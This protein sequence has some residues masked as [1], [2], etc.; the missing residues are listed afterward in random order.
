MSEGNGI[1]REQRVVKNEVEFRAYN[2]RREQMERGT[3][4]GP[5]PFV[6]ECGDGQCIRALSATAEE[7]ERAHAREDQFLVLPGH[8][9]PEYERV[10]ERGDRHWVVQK[11]VRPSDALDG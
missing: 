9:Y 4:E 7:W 6:C 5:L 8:V 11:F 1:P 2:D 3:A 10:V